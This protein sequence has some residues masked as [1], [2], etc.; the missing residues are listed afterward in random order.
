[1]KPSELAIKLEELR[2]RFE[3]EWDP[4]DVKSIA[5]FIIEHGGPFALAAKH[6]AALVDALGKLVDKVGDRCGGLDA[7]ALGEAWVNAGEL[8][9][10]IEKESKV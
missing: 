3:E 9:A 5:E 8:L 10:T 4:E 1:M 7:P 2:S 6:H